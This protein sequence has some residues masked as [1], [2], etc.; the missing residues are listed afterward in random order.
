[1]NHLSIN[2]IKRSNPQLEEILAVFDEEAAM[3]NDMKP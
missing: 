3:F 2:A 1:M